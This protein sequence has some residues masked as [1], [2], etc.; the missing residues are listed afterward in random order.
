MERE[1][2]VRIL[3]TVTDDM[4][5]QLTTGIKLEDGPARFEEVVDSGGEGAN[6]WYHVVLMEGR[7]REVRRMW[8]AVGVK[9]SRLMRVRYANAILTKSQRPGKHREMSYKEVVEL[10]EMVGMKFE[11]PAYDNNQNKQSR[12]T[13]NR[14]YSGQGKS[15]SRSKAGHEN[16]KRR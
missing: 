1:Y 10:A 6:H 3:G 7:N 15:Q 14:G 16:K 12:A 8:E 4:L 11:V 5:K 9:V 2:A 13:G